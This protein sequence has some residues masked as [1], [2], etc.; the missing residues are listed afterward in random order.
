MFGDDPL[1][2]I[3]ES[4]KKLF[5][6]QLNSTSI[7]PQ[8]ISSNNVKELGKNS[9]VSGVSQGNNTGNIAMVPMGNKSNQSLVRNDTGP[10]LTSGPTMK[11]HP[12]FDVDNFIAPINMANF[13]VV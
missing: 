13:N 5:L 2:K 4:E 9:G 11:I 8:E 12:N 1:G 3:E 6:N 7:K 10:V